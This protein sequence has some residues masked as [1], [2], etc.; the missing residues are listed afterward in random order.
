[1]SRGGKRPGAGRPR[2]SVSKKAR[3]KAAII[4]AGGDTPLDILLWAARQA[5]ADGDV[6]RARQAARDAAPYFHQRFS[7]TDQLATPHKEQGMLP[8]FPQHHR[9]PESV[10]K[11][12]QAQ[13]DAETAGAGTDWGDD[14]QLAKPN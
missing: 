1:M 7:P 14:L 4:A 9:P 3:V 8:L 13:R 12:E 2:G 5:K 11:K 6:D 10:G